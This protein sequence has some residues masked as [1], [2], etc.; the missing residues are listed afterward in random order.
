MLH[1]SGIGVERRGAQLITPDIESQLWAKG[2]LG[3]HSPQALLTAVFFYNGKNFCL[4]GIHEH[5]MPSG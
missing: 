1:S 5:H 2:F 3:L 4:Q